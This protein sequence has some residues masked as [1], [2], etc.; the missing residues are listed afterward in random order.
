MQK[1]SASKL[2]FAKSSFNTM[3]QIVSISIAI[4]LGSFIYNSIKN[5]LSFLE[6]LDS[7]QIL[8][9]FL[10]FKVSY[11]VL[12]LSGLASFVV[13]IL[14]YPIKIKLSEKGLELSG[15]VFGARSIKWNEIESF[16]S[17]G[18]SRFLLFRLANGNDEKIDL[19][20]FKDE[21]QKLIFGGVL[22]QKNEGL[23]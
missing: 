6:L 23:G 1:Y 15:G 14:K 5:D 10:K 16:K 18:P 12:F 9:D 11:L 2:K 21:I 20:L 13:P 4:L 7:L 19:H 22:K 3:V 17:A 8:K